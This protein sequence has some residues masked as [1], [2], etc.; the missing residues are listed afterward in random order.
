MSVQNL[1]KR[2]KSKNQVKAEEEKRLNKAYRIVYKGKIE[3]K[4]ISP[5]LGGDVNKLTDEAIYACERLKIKPD[6]LVLRNIEWF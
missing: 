1:N 3:P 5:V 2:K 4:V 6:E